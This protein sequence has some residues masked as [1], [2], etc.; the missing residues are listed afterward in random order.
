MKTRLWELGKSVLILLLTC[1]LIFLTIAAMPAEMIRST[2]WLSSLLQPIAPLLGLSQAELTYVEESGSLTD[3]AQ[4][5]LI[6]VR[7]SAGRATAQWSFSALDTAYETLGGIL[8]EALDTADSLTTVTDTQ[9]H[10]ALSG[11]SALFDFRFSLPAQLLASWLDAGCQEDAP[12]ASIYVLAIEGEQVNLYLSGSSIYRAATQI[13]VSA[14]EELLEQFKPDSSQFAFEAGSSLSP[15]TI[16]PAQ[17][18]TVAAGTAVS[19]CDTRYMEALATDLGFN[20]YD[21]NRYTDSR[22]VTYFSESNCSLQISTDGTILLTSASSDRFQAAGSTQEVLVEKALNLID[23]AIGSVIG[24]ARLY[25]SG[26]THSGETTTCRFDYILDGIPVSCDGES[27]ASVT[28]RGQSVTELRLQ[29]LA[30]SLTSEELKIMPSAQAIAIL[31]DG[32]KLEL[33]YHCSY[34][35][36]LS[37][38]WI[39]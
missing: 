11:E 6:S 24:D 37:A 29:A 33:E 19:P 7:N 9:L 23:L 5:L 38:G 39:K 3:A 2:P 15:L 21:E 27:A 4:P 17:I 8:G 20:P 26:I 14:L 28:F 18:P 16:L 34:S 36:S 35:G 12:A 25:L 22:G 31:P 1:S 13:T 10:T 32:G 30:F